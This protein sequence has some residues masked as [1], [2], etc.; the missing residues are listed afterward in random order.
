MINIIEETFPMGIC[1]IGIRMSG[2][3]DSSLAAY[4]I[5][6]YSLKNNLGLNIIP[7]TIVEET[8]PFQLQFTSGVINILNNILPGANIP[9]PIVYHYS[10]GLKIQKFREVEKELFDSNRIELMVSGTTK[11]PK[12][13]I[14]YGEKMIW[15]E[16][17]DRSTDSNPY[18]WDNKIYTPL[19]NMDKKGV[20]A[21]YKKYDLMDVLFP[22]TRSCVTATMDFSKHCGNCWWCKER[23]WAFGTL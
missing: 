21:L 15:D 16:G 23:E 3:A 9:Q 17:G 14:G 11:E 22:H 19:F 18:L 7:V 10:D 20:A 2:G 12:E 8:A 13:D 6:V 5:S 1:D 4:L